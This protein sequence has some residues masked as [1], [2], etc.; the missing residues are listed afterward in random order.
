MRA[1]IGRSLLRGRAGRLVRAAERAEVEHAAFC[2]HGRV[3]L[4]PAQLCVRAGL[5]R[6]GERAVAVRVKGH[7]RKRRE[8]IGADQN[9]AR[10]DPG[11]AHRAGQQMAESVVADL[12][13]ESGLFA[14]GAERRKAVAGRAAR[15]GCQRGIAGLVFGALCQIDK[16]LAQ[17]DHI[18]HRSV[19]LCFLLFYHESSL[20]STAAGEKMRGAFRLYICVRMW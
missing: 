5:A 3:D 7:E 6:E 12:G 11:A 19:L 20:D 9:A 14:V 13:E 10:V 18:I 8:C 17:R 4:L 16:Q 15:I 2:Q 1:G